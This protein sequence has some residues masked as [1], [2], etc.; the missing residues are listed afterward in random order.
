MET[1]ALTCLTGFQPPNEFENQLR[2]IHRQTCS[3]AVAGIFLV[4]I[5]AGCKPAITEPQSSKNKLAAADKNHAYAGSSSCQKCH[6]E[7]YQLWSAS[8]HGLA[9][10]PVQP[11][12][13]QSA[14]DPPR[15]FQHGSETTEVAVVNGQFHVKTTGFS[16]HAETFP[17]ERVI[18][19]DPLRQ[20]LVA[21]PG[22]RMQTLEASY[23]PNAK[24]WFDSFGNEDRKPGEWGHWTGRGMN[25]N[26]MCAVCHNTR[27]QKSYEA[28]NDSYHTTMAEPTVGC[29]A[30]HGPLLAH[31]E[32]QEKFG[33]SG[34][35]DPTVAKLSHEQ[36]VDYCGTCH[37]RRADLTGDFLPGDNFLDRYNLEMAG[38]E[39]YYYLD[40]QI[41]E[42]DYEYASFL[43]SRMHARGVHCLDCHNPH[44]YK[45]I[46]PG[47]WLCLRCHAEGSKTAP[48]INPVTHSHHK[49]YGFDTNGQ[50]ANVDLT[51]YNSKTV[52]ETG[53][54]CV[55]CH[56]PQTI[57]MQRHWRHDH[58]FTS[59]DPLLTKQF[60]IPNACNRCHQDKSADWALDASEKWYGTNFGGARRPRAQAF[61]R[62]NSGDATAVAPLLA[63][64]RGDEQPYWKAAA[65]NALAPWSADARVTDALV[66]NLDN[67]NALVRTKAAQA[68]DFAAQS[69]DAKIKE[70]LRG[71]LSDPIR[72]VR[73]EAAWDLRAELKPGEPVTVELENFLNLNADQPGGQMQLGMF[74]FARGNEEAALKHYQK[75]AEWDAFSAP[76]QHELAVVYSA[77]NRP[78]DA[79]I[80]LQ[81]AVKLAPR[82]A[83]YQFELGLAWNEA[84]DLA[85]AQSAFESAVRLS[86]TFARAWYNLGLARSATGQ[87]QPA[88]EALL[89]AESADATDAR[90][91]YARATIL[92][93]QGNIEEAKAAARRALELQPDFSAARE[94]F[95]QLSTQ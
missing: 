46:L 15:S 4:A 41:R 20:F 67:T 75:A 39:D 17:V 33:K 56:M 87:L 60:G 54:E 48:N 36:I 79:V 64:L 7:E 30:C 84:G 90:A 85:Q 70:A 14:F 50:P 43:S 66:E 77:L 8:H 82:E 95:N 73:L 78:Q 13:D 26:M 16:G 23:D 94:L 27:L 58:G 9:E 69:D 86:P 72:S 47:N 40:G 22:G 59:P 12:F 19:H 49:V 35:K 51:T 24:E 10:R 80:A 5:V 81:A 57:Y 21:F 62:A 61:A 88:V 74:E 89:H 45:T 34:Q 25:W 1:A 44:S 55:N 53:G 11:L 68:L 92:A 93:R 52:K 38:T 32:W 3:A 2:K 83:Q 91:P 63:L 31:N 42:E 71:R 28:T 76:I 65:E 37:S 29:E 18:G 6:E